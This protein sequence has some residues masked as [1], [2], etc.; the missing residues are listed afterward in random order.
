M[1][2]NSRL[3][4]GILALQ[5]AFTEHAEMIRALRAEPVLLRLPGE[6]DG[7]DGLILPGGES[8][9]IGWL[10]GRFHFTERI[11]RMAQAG[12]PIFGTCAGMILLARKLAGDTSDPVGAGRIGVMN[13]VVRR[14]AFGRQLDSF[15]ED[16]PIPAIGSKPFPAVFIRAP[17]VVKA[18]KGVRV[19]ARLADGGC[20]AA[21]EGSLLA[22][23][24]HPELTADTRIHGY[25]LERVSFRKAGRGVR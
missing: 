4:I 19:L 2:G 25:F 11:R 5:G 21:V 16:L 8:T 12:F 20:V 3:K 17:V 7:V 23:A 14:N 1:G 15:E 22:T 6:I 24:F 9:A 10:M 18:G 13:L